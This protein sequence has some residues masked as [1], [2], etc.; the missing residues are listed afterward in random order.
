MFRNRQR[1]QRSAGFPQKGN[2]TMAVLGMNGGEEKG[3]KIM[4]FTG[5]QIQEARERIRPF[6]DET[7][8]LRLKGLDAYLGC[9]VYIKAECMQRTGAFKF[10]GAMNRI[11]TLTEHHLSS[12]VHDGFFLGLRSRLRH[13]DHRS[14]PLHPGSIGD[15]PSVV[16]RRRRHDPP[17]K[18]LLC[19]RQDPVRGGGEDLQ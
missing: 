5:K 4:E 12:Q 1:E 3:E 18:L 14:G 16:S 15:G 13:Y 6:V 11:L 10:R 17:G 7:P 8:L 2:W 9:Q 19:Q